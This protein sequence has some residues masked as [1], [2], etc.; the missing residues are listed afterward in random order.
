MKALHKSGTQQ[1]RVLVYLQDNG[2][3]LP[4]KA[5][6]SM[7]ITYTQLMQA[8]RPLI[9]R[10]LAIMSKDGLSLTEEGAAFTALEDTYR[11]D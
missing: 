3:T 4:Q 10:G 11:E 8:A 2:P 6:Q 5:A 9:R 1:R 7:R